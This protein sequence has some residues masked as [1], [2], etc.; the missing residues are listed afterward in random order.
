MIMNCCFLTLKSTTIR[1]SPDY[2]IPP[3]TFSGSATTQGSYVG[4][5][6][7]QPHKLID[8]APMNLHPPPPPGPYWPQGN[9]ETTAKLDHIVLKLQKLDSIEAQ[10]A[11]ILSRLN[12]IDIIIAENK[13][14]IE[15]TDKKVEAIEQSQKFISDQYEDVTKGTSVNKQEL[16]KIQGEAKTLFEKSKLL[17]EENKTLTEDNKTL[18][19]DN[20][21]M[22]EDILDLKCRSMQDNLV[23]MGISEYSETFSTQQMDSEPS[24]SFDTRPRTQP[25]FAQAATAGEDCAGKILIFCEKVLGIED[26][27]KICIDRAHRMGNTAP[28]KTRAVVVKF[29][30][31]TSKLVIK[32][33]LKKA[34][35]K[36]TPYF[37]FDQ[38]PKAIQERRKALIPDMIKARREGKTAFLVRDKLYVNNKPYTSR[39]K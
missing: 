20:T 2:V 27:H 3:V 9:A 6:I 36:D 10:Q 16:V 17:F 8:F 1:Y 35:L 32:E 38:Y 25:L 28:G 12:Q 37:V 26:T 34:N 22:N 7:I 33:A 21:C 15:S 13:R 31:T 30:D 18:K 24:E 39:F 4:S 19:A 11:N 29:K 23:F 5:N 14:K